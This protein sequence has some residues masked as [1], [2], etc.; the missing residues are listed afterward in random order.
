[1]RS[2]LL[3][4]A[5]GVAGTAAM[6]AY[7]EL[8][9]RARGGG[10]GDGGAPTWDEAPAPAQVARKAAERAAGRTPPAERIPLLTNAMHW[11]YGIGWGAVYGVVRSRLRARPFLHGPLFGTL[12]WLGSYAQLV[13]LGVYEPPWEY[14]PKTLAT[15]WSYHVVYGL[16]VAGA[17]EAAAATQ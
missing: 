15:D 12:V 10:D 1:M 6:T 17:F 8:V 9:G 4:L 16:G 3:G 7:Q 5:A 14:G 2:L 11:A 13:P